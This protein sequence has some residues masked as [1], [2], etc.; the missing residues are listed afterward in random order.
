LLE[1]HRN[2]CRPQNSPTN[3]VQETKDLSFVYI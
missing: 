1:E 2:N 3:E